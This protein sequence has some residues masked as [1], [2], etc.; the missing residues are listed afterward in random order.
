[1]YNN[2]MN[3]TN[4]I[5]L[6][7]EHNIK[8]I[9]ISPGGTNMAFV[10]KIQDDS[11]FNCY[12]VVD[13]RSAMYFAI[14][15]YLQTGNIIATS[16]TSAQATRNYIPGLTEAF[17]KKVPILAITM[18]KHPRFTYQEYMQAPD[19]CS[20]P[21]DCVKRSF[22]LPF[23]SDENDMLHS[24][25]VINEAI[26][27][28]TH[29]G[30][31]PVQLCV[32][33]LDRKTKFVSKKSNKIER[34]YFDDLKRCSE[35]LKNK[36]I[37][38][39]IGE[40]RPFNNNLKKLIDDFCN[41][42]N[43]F[44]YVNHLSNFENDYSINGNLLLSCM[45]DDD[46]YKVKPDILITMGGQTG[47]YP[48]YNM[49]SNS[50]FYEIDHWRISESGDVVDTYDKLSSIFEMSEELFFKGI[51]ND[52]IKEKKDYYQIW[53]SNYILQNNKITLPFSNA[54]VAQLLSKKIVKPSIIQFS[55]LNSL[56]VWNL[57]ALNKNV[58]CYSNVGAFGI[59]GGMSTLIGQSMVTDKDCY[60]IIGDLAFLYDIN[61]LSIRNI[62][63]N[64]KILLINNNGGVEFKLYDGNENFNK[65]NKYVAAG[66]HFKNAKGWSETCGFLYLSA[67]N[68]EEFNEN[69]DKFINESN[70]P[71]VFELFVNDVD[72]VKAYNMI[73]QA[74]SKLTIS[75]YTGYG[76]KILKKGIKKILNR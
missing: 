14:G 3:I 46:F 27:E 53:K 73:I 36:K 60:M 63:N 19:Q 68:I 57:F 30:C 54:Y 69:I 64:L 51:I 39:V 67:S 70:K 59:D 28:L 52:N 37:M 21:N 1:M 22:S 33:A 25:R 7:K 2:E 11:F 15:L 49:L 12:S 17:Y 56:R 31:G 45:K 6:L 20:L 23:I 41:N 35:K 9:V 16:C 38:L 48:L 43:C 24:M 44:I 18:S 74:N 42:Y 58:E 13:E 72:E 47:D 26:L 5:M 55:I 40:H 34:Y 76:K 75:D 62:K 29:H 66:D 50:I 65:I 32:P 4:L 10:K 8:D 61:S 71:V